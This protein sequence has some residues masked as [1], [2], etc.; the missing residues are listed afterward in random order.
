MSNVSRKCARW[1]SGYIT[2]IVFL[3]K[4]FLATGTS[5]KILMLNFLSRTR[6]GVANE[7][8]RAVAARSDSPLGPLGRFSMVFFS[9]AARPIAIFIPPIIKHSVVW[10]AGTVNAKCL[11]PGGRKC[12]MPAVTKTQM[13]NVQM[14]SDRP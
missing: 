1:L 7:K 14:F 5:G 8:I 6:R 9:S 3:I 13:S 4:I 11:A 10:G 2:T 12:H